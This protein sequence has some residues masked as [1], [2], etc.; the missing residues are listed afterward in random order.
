MEDDSVPKLIPYHFLYIKETP[1]Q[2]ELRLSYN[3]IM[4]EEGWL[5]MDKKE[6]RPPSTPKKSTTSPLEFLGQCF[7][8][9]DNVWTS[10]FDFEI[11]G[12]IQSPNDTSFHKVRN[13][14]GNSEIALNEVCLTALLPVDH[15][16]QSY[17]ED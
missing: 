1:R 4:T 2:K 15:L 16:V 12:S 13:T 7:D 3:W 9:R 10:S 6:I 5:R 17:A 11:D 14:V 8:E